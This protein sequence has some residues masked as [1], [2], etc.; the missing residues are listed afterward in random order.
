MQRHAQIHKRRVATQVP[1]PRVVRPVRPV[2]PQR[3]LPPQRGR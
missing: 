2:R 1:S 3:K